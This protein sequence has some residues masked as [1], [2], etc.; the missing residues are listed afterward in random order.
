MFG[1]LS[2]LIRLYLF[3][4]RLIIAGLPC[5]YLL[6][7]VRHYS[8]MFEAQQDGELSESCTMILPK[9]VKVFHLYLLAIIVIERLH[10][11]FEE[12]GGWGGKYFGFARVLV[13]D[14]WLGER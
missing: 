4:F 2:I 5:L 13:V 8:L 1:C 10:V 3:L 9:L 6:M 14:Y 7:L 11:I 12:E